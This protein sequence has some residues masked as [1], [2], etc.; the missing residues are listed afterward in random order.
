MRHILLLFSLV[1]SFTVISQQNVSNSLKSRIYENNLPG[2]NFDVLIEGTFRNRK[3]QR[4]K[5]LE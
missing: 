2:A 5:R 1:L 3:K 4:K